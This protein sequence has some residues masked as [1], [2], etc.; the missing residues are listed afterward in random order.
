MM[1]GLQNLWISE[2]FFLFEEGMNLVWD[3]TSNE[4]THGLSFCIS[5]GKLKFYFILKSLEEI[6][7]ETLD[8][9]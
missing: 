3:P 4:V 8:L 6:L 9:P 2:K 5:D 1:L 7:Q